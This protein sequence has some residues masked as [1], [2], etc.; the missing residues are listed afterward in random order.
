[1][2][3]AYSN[4]LRRKFLEAYQ[5]GEGSLETLAGR[6]GVSLGWAEKIWRRLRE[7]GKME[8]PAGGKRGPASKVTPEIQK[9]LQDW[10]KQQPD[11]T[12]E[13]LRGQL[14]QQLRLRISVSRLWMV[15]RD[16]DLRLKKSHSM[17]P[18]KTLQR[19]NSGVAYG[20]QRRARSI[21]TG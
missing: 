16:L 19:A 10:V 6:F 8:R 4:D 13:E 18:S 21:R 2:A 11:L 1:M 3:S 7:S 17:P 15:L 14:K 20:G 5:R 12:L 9:H